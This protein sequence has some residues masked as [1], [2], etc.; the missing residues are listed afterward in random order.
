MILLLEETFVK[1]CWLGNGQ[2][3]AAAWVGVESLDGLWTSLI[4]ETPG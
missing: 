1:V 4:L 3:C 2:A